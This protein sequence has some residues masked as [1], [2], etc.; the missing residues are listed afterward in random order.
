MPAHFPGPGGSPWLPSGEPVAHCLWWPPGHVAGRHLAPY[1]ASIDKTVKPDL[2][3][4]PPGLPIAAPLAQA[5]ATGDGSA[6][7]GAALRHDA[8]SRQVMAARRTAREGEHLVQ[9]LRRRGQD[10]DRH[11]EEVIAELRA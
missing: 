1:L 10:F 5:P 6:A 8:I 7:G 11:E 4:H 9:V 3:W 2:P